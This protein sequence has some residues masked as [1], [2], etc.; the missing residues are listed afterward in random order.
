MQF[1]FF[2]Q[3]LLNDE[4]EK[5]RVSKSMYKEKWTHMVHI[6]TKQTS[7]E[8][9]DELAELE[10]DYERFVWLNGILTEFS[11]VLWFS[12]DFFAD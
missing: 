8:D 10:E 2:F 7:S 1:W 4:L 12:F 5:M 11:K 9:S 6:F 3:K